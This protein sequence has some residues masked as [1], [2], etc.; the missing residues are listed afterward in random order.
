ML[1]IDH[2]ISSQSFLFHILSKFLRWLTFLIIRQ[3]FLWEFYTLSHSMNWSEQRVLFSFIIF[4]ECYV[5][6]ISPR[7]LYWHFISFFLDISPPVVDI[8]SR[9]DLVAYWGQH[10]GNAGYMLTYLAGQR[11]FIILFSF[12]TS[13]IGKMPNALLILFCISSFLAHT[14]LLNAYSAIML[15]T[16]GMHYQQICR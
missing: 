10:W 12:S 13:I 15:L 6:E 16:P 9:F 2:G 14:L 4:L 8:A 11:G 1:A 5:L 3:R 7:L